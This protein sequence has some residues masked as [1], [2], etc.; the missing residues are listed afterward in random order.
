MDEEQMIGNPSLLLNAVISVFRLTGIQRGGSLIDLIP[1][2]LLG[3]ETIWA[4]TDAG[5]LVFRIGDFATRQLLLYGRPL[6]DVE[7][8]RIVCAL[9]PS[10]RGMLDI[11]ASY[12]WYTKLATNLMSPQAIK[13]ALEANPEVAAPLGRSFSKLPGVLVLNVAA[14]DRARRVCFYCARRSGLSSAVRAVGTQ[15]V[16]EGLPADDIWPTDQP[17]DFV[18]CDV[19]GGE[20][21]VL[22]GARRIRREHE[23]IWMLEFD[24]RFLGEAGVEPSEVSGELSDLLCW[25]RSDSD[26]WL[27][28][29]SLGAVIGKT[30]ICKNVFLVPRS[31]AYKF[32]QLMKQQ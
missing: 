2:R 25:W 30:R 11:G 18:K 26:G 21:E 14:T 23:P 3:G 5:P 29:D 4:N 32:A 15:T 6:S 27:L 1:P 16:V 24:E 20:L 9:L 28:A 10:V 12:G 13:I 31:R 7:E 19:E 22:R 8:T 17:L